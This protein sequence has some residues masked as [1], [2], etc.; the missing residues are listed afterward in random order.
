M[1]YYL[2]FSFILLIVLTSSCG[3]K[4]EP[5]PQSMPSQQEWEEGHGILSNHVGNPTT[6]Y[7][8]IELPTDMIS[9]TNNIEQHTDYAVPSGKWFLNN[10]QGKFGYGITGGTREAGT[11]Y[12][13]SLFDHSEYGESFHRDIRIQLSERDNDLNKKELVS[14]EVVHIDTVQGEQEVYSG[15]LPDKENI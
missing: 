4:K 7:E 13:L 5:S 2:L 11:E 12:T 8:P 9:H 3:F 15:H 10:G 14:E 6:S 1:K